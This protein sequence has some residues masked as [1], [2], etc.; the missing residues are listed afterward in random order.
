VVPV[1][2]TWVGHSTVQLALP[3]LT[4]LTD[5]FFASRLGPLRRHGPAPDPQALAEPDVVLVSHAHPDHFHPPSLRHLRGTPLVVAPR[6]LRRRIDRARPGAGVEELRPGEAV[7]VAGWRVTAVPA[8]HWRSPLEPVVPAIG[9]LLEGP[10]GAYFAGDTSRF[11]GM[12]ELA[13]RVDLALLPIGRWG[14]QPT[15]GH[16]GPRTAALV[17]GAI[18]ARVVVPIHWGTLY[19]LGL[20]RLLPGPLRE[21]APRF[22]AA[23]R[24]DAPATE[25]L[26]LAPGDT[27]TVALPAREATPPGR[28]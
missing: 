11:A 3:G 4:V 2:V 5:P 1:E 9:F 14:P 27:G 23:A 20:E 16:L 24:R 26:V 8:R 22:E 12:A 18:G 13:G 7:E 19:P 25:V 17:A 6:G 15:P 10:V 28:G 21:P